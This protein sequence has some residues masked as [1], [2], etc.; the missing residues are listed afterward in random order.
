MRLRFLVEGNTEGN[1]INQILIPYL[2]GIGIKAFSAQKVTTSS[3]RERQFKGGSV[4]YEKFIRELIRLIKSDTNAIYTTMLDYY[5]LPKDFKNTDNDTP[6]AIEDKIKND[7]ENEIGSY[8]TR[9]IPYIQKHEFETLLLVKPQEIGNYFG[10]TN[11]VSG[12]LSEIRGY[13]DIEDINNTP[14]GAPSKRIERYFP[15]YVSSKSTAGPIIA[16]RIGL[17]LMRTRCKK[18]NAWINKIEEASKQNLNQES[19]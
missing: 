1:Y 2:L 4:S 6:E 19:L 12:L 14:E 8:P 13:S 17:D 7:I 16:K 15:A 18:F 10:D 11:K 3:H 9:I 5:A